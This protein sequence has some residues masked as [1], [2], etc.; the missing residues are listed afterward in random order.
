MS[1]SFLDNLVQ[2]FPFSKGLGAILE[3][4]NSNKMDVGSMEIQ[5]IKKKPT[6]GQIYLFLQ[7]NS[8]L[9]KERR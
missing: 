5:A 6:C 4:F 7:Q 1:L 8:S 3:T 2:F 9:H